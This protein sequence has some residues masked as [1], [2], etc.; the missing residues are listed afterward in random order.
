[1]ITYLARRRSPKKL[2]AISTPGPAGTTT[3]SFHDLPAN[4]ALAIVELGTNDY[5]ISTVSAFR[6]HYVALL[7]RIQ[8][9]SP[10]VTLLCLSIWRSA[11]SP[12]TQAFNAVIDQSCGGPA[13]FVNISSLFD[14]AANRGP[15][16]R[17]TWDGMPGD[18]FH[19]ND[20]GY[21]AITARILQHLAF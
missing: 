14:N 4:A 1:V 17:A 19:P 11:H 6:A 2:D 21:R 12:K 10:R 8:E 16:G 7:R 13:H 9:S 18:D 15:V 3:L 5:A 20:R